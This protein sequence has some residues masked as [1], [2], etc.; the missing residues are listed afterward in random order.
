MLFVSINSIKTRQLLD[1]LTTIGKPLNE[2]AINWVRRQVGVV[3]VLVGAR[4]V[5]QV[6]QNVAAL[7]W[8]LSDEQYEKIEEIVKGYVHG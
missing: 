1:Q 8:S 4:S 6:K 7:S 3:S 2:V 5:D